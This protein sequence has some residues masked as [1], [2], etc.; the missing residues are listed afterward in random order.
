MN[1]ALRGPQTRLIAQRWALLG[2]FVGIFVPL[3]VFG[4]LAEDV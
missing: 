2:L 3:V 4:E 1:T